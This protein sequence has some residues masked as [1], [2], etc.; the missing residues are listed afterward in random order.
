MIRIGCRSGKKKKSK[1][2]NSVFTTQN[3]FQTL[4]LT[5]HYKYMQER[6]SSCKDK[7]RDI[8]FRRQ[9]L[10]VKKYFISFK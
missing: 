8:F 5:I 4:K 3:L 7:V 9:N 10:T 2:G 1:G 6:D